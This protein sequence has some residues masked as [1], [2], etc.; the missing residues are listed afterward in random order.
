MN[1]KR[2]LKLQIATNFEDE[3]INGLSN[4][5]D[6]TWVYGKLNKDVIGGGRNSI[7][8]PELSWKELKKHVDLC[9]KHNIKFNYLLNSLCLGG[10]EFTNDF[11]N[12]LIQLLDKCA[13]ANIDGITV[14]TPYL[15]ELIKTQYPQFIISISDY[16]RIT[17][18]QQLAYWNDIGADEITFFP[19]VNR[20]FK[21]LKDFLYFTKDTNLTLRVI[22]NN[23]C[24]RECAFHENHGVNNSHNSRKDS[25]T[26]D[27]T[28][29][30]HV[31][32]CNNFKVKHPTQYVAAEWIRPEDIHYYEKLCEETGNYNLSI[33]LTDRSK[34]SEFLLRVAKAYSDRQYHGNLFEIL[35]MATAKER[36]QLHIEKFIDK[37]IKGSYNVEILKKMPKIHQTPEMYLDNQKLD[38]FLDKFVKSFDCLS[39]ICD[40]TEFKNDENDIKDDGKCG[41]C[42]TWKN[43]AFTINKREQME[44][45]EN[46]DEVIH[47]LKESKIICFSNKK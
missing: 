26:S 25:F 28:V 34:T 5:N 47:D 20:N 33:K 18:I 35:N 41:Y 16:N 14:A 17:T 19:S 8:L 12:Q 30:Y 23:C 9:H 37:A 40:D 45:I 31:L 42:R 2:S 24:L 4:F 22:G 7:I 43:K 44:W 10:K 46:S 39:K 13:E 21:K 36:K 38:G 11:H 3:L 27:F 6:I 15:C 1:T 32:K 29:D